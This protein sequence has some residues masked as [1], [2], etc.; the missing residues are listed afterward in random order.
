MNKFTIVLATMAGCNAVA[1]AEIIDFSGLANGEIVNHQFA[2]LGVHI[3]AINPNRSFDLAGIFDTNASGTRD[4]DLEGPWSMGN[5]PINTDMGNILIIQENDQGIPDDEGSR[6]AGA[7]FFNFDNLMSTFGFDIL[8]L[9]STAAEI[10]SIEFFRNGTYIS[11]MGFDQFEAGGAY[12]VNAI[13]GNNSINRIDPFTIAGGFDEV[14]ISVGGSM[15]FDNI[16]FT[17]VPAPGALALL[18]LG[19]AVG[20]RRRR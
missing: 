19:A 20:I 5:M 11:G 3:S 13:F 18:G 8:D 6:P 15:G 16:Q 4:N 2:P 9:D 1:H 14:M 10:S 7:L 17:Q 12:D